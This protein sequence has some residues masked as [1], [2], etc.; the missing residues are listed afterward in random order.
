MEFLHPL[1]S[2]TDRSI[3]ARPKV[4]GGKIYI[5]KVRGDCDWQL[6]LIGTMTS[7]RQRKVDRGVFPA[8]RRARGHWQPMPPVNMQVSYITPR[9]SVGDSQSPRPPVRSPRH[10]SIQRPNAAQSL[11]V[12]F[13]RVVSKVAVSRSLSRQ[14]RNRLTEM[15]AEQRRARCTLISFPTWSSSKSSFGSYACSR[16]RHFFIWPS[17]FRLLQLW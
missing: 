13:S 9:N 11:F 1:Y 10:L 4:Q 16:R 14:V 17:K 2:Q 8:T 6:Q 7:V 5:R 15:S 3:W 12:F